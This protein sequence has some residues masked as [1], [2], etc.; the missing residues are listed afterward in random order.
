MAKMCLRHGIMA[1]V[2]SAIFLLC[3]C[4]TPSLTKSRYHFN[5]PFFYHTL[6]VGPFPLYENKG[7][8]FNLAKLKLNKQSLSSVRI[9]Y[10]FNF[11]LDT[12][13][14]CKEFPENQNL[15]LEL[16]DA[17]KLV[18]PFK[19]I[20]PSGFIDGERLSDGRW[21]YRLSEEL[22]MPEKKVKQSY[23]CKLYIHSSMP[24]I[25]FEDTAMVSIQFKEML[26]RK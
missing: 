15:E 18:Y 20:I 26:S 9:Y 21:R 24:N 5:P 16:W 3:G 23:I 6:E 10:I 25:N 17:G 4:G 12:L 19:G 1:T 11:Q 22:Y 8:C 7:Y 2:A 13:N 14:N